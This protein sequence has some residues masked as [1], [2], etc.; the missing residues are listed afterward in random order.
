M[1]SAWQQDL[2]TFAMHRGCSVAH[3]T[4]EQRR[5]II[6]AGADFVIINF[7]GVAVVQDAIRNGGFDLIVVDEANA[8]KNVQ[9]NRWKIL[10]KLVDNVDWLWMLTV[11]PL[12][13]LL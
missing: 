12:L 13:S 4:A 8:Y 11:R 3:G 2:F 10:K 6:D 7:D 1:K 9:T 5:K